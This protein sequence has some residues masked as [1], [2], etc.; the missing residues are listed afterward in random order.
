M[1]EGEDTAAVLW[2]AGGNLHHVGVDRM[3][4]LV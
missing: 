2:G 3:L 1:A 4:Y